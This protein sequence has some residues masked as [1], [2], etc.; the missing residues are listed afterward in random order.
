MTRCDIARR[1]KGKTWQ[2]MWEKCFSI[3]LRMESFSPTISSA[4]AEPTHATLKSSLCTSMQILDAA[5]D[6]PTRLCIQVGW[7]DGCQVA[8]GPAASCAASPF[9]SHLTCLTANKRAS[10]LRPTEGT[11]ACRKWANYIKP[12]EPG[13]NAGGGWADGGRKKTGWKEAGSG[14]G[15]G[16]GFQSGQLIFK[17]QAGG[18]LVTDKEAALSSRS[19]T[20]SHSHLLSGRHRESG[21][22][23]R[24]LLPLPLL[25]PGAFKCVFWARANGFAL[26][27][28]SRVEPSLSLSRFPFKPE[29]ESDLLAMF[30]HTKQGIFLWLVSSPPT[31]LTQ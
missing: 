1:D 5:C 15:A 10:Q 30:V 8:L 19:L 26:R 18:V 20:S 28:G 25:R 31:S 16:F 21:K 3:D 17:Q 11:C 27:P 23:L 2:P 7:T 29:S 12:G 13:V 22:Q 9:G 4:A 24:A 6:A 14:A